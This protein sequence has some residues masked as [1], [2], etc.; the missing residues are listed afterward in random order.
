MQE[1]IIQFIKVDIHNNRPDIQVTAQD[2][3]LTSGLL[4]S[5]E[6]VRLIEFLEKT[7]AISIPPQDMNIDHFISVAAMAEYVQTRQAA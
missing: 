4:S 1:Q 6:M 5:M 7:F 2:D 3:L